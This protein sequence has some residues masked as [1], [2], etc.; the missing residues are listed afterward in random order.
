MSNTAADP[1]APAPPPVAELRIEPAG[2]QL[3]VPPGASLLEAAQ[4]AGIHL[5]RSCRNGTCRA[6]L[7]RLQVGQAG[8]VRWRIDW[9]GL[10]ADEKREGWILPCV[11]EAVPGQTLVIAQ[12][13]A[14]RLGG[15]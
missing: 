2:W 12:P 4:Q 13:A 10:S 15:E 11:A 14:R 8:Q 5:P 1:V 7:C 6:C 9:P 3:P